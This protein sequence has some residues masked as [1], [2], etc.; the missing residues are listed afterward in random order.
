MNNGRSAAKA[1]SISMT[2]SSKPLILISI[3]HAVQNE[4]ASSTGASALRLICGAKWRSRCCM[5]GGVWDNTIRP[6]AAQ[7]TAEQT[8]PHLTT[9]ASASVWCSGFR[10]TRNKRLSNSPHLAQ[11]KVDE[12]LRDSNIPVTE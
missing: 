3:L 10:R 7:P 11:R 2:V 12:S 6:S 8:K 9:P 5:R 1:R 4:V